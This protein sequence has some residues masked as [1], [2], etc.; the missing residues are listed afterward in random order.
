[1]G[2]GLRA[3][4][5]GSTGVPARVSRDEATALPLRELAKLGLRLAFDEA[6]ERMRPGA[7]APDRFNLSAT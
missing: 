6:D 5:G 2:L 7:H 4:A 1:M 3:N